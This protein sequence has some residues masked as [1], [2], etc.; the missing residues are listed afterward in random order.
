[1]W[2]ILETVKSILTKLETGKL[3]FSTEYTKKVAE[4]SWLAEEI[5]ADSFIL[6]TVQCKDF[7]YASAMVDATAAVQI[8]F[9]VTSPDG[10]SYAW[11]PIGNMNS[12]SQKASCQ[13]NI[14]GM[15]Y[16]TV[17]VTNAGEAS[18]TASLYLYLGLRGI[19]E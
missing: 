16:V 14:T 17:V 2:A 19:S 13:A 7:D 8:S 15:P 11:D 4:H 6:K 10:S 3:Q 18:V 5:G 9:R 12:A 1:M